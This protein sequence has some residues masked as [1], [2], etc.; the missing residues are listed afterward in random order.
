MLILILE[1]D[2]QRIK[3]FERKFIGHSLTIVSS[4]K[5]IIQKLGEN[6][7]DIVSLNHDLDGKVYVPSGPGTGYEVAEWLAAHPNRQPTLIFIHSLNDRGVVQNMK[8]VL[9]HAHWVP[10]LWITSNELGG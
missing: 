6:Y 4:V 7:Y 3:K 9:P 8:R 10:H 5:E 2:P 1:D